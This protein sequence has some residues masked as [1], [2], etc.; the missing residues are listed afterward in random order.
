MFKIMIIILLFLPV[1][2]SS[3]IIPIKFIEEG[4]NPFYNGFIELYE[5][6]IK[7]ND[8]VKNF[9]YTDTIAVVVWIELNKKSAE[10]SF[11]FSIMQ[12]VY[13]KNR[14]NIRAPGTTKTYYINAYDKLKTMKSIKDSFAYIIKGTNA[15]RELINEGKIN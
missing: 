15:L 11:T 2:A 4:N 1:F 13:C 7:S 6:M 12:G 5:I 10:T 8:T 14:G 9:T 3:Q